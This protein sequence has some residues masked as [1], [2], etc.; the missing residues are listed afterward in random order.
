[1]YH[2]TVYGSGKQIPLALDLMA[3]P[4]SEPALR[5]AYRRLELSNHLSFEQIMSVRAQAIVV[6]NLAEAIVRRRACGDSTRN[7]SIAAANSEAMDPE[8]S[9]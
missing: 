4:E 7:T 1:M 6:R 3:D 8:F 2:R 9:T 5:A